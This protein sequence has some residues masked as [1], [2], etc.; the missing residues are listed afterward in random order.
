MKTRTINLIDNSIRNAIVASKLFNSTLDFDTE[1]HTTV[2][3][4]EET[5]EELRILKKD[6]DDNI[7]KFIIKM[8][9][10]KNRL[11]LKK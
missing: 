6:A 3:E 8:L 7:N 10:M 2:L 5:M 9:K 1:E 4:M 11:R